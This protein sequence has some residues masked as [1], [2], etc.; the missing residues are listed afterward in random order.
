MPNF[1]KLDK[2]NIVENVLVIPK[3]QAKRGNAYLSKDL[4]LGGKWVECETGSVGY[5]YNEPLGRFEP[6]KPFDS[7]SW[8]EEEGNWAAPIPRPG[9]YYYW[10]EDTLSWL[11]V[12]LPI[13]NIV[14]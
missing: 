10:K 1:A 7:W 4:G 9:A 13:D 8:S 14:A 11:P 3:D 2:N 12:E 6:P 5:F